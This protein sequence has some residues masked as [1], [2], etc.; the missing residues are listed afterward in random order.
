MSHAKITVVVVNDFA[1]INGGASKVAI[2]SA[3]S[4]S[5]AGCEVIF[6]AAVGPVCLQLVESKVRVI[7]LD[8]PSFV[9]DPK[10]LRAA[11]RGLWNF[12]SAHGFKSLL[13]TLDPVRTVVH[14]HSW[15]KALSSSVLVPARAGKFSVILTLHDYFTACPNGG[16]YNYPEQRICKLR[17]LSARCIG[18]NC[19]SRSYAYK[20]YRLLRQYVQRRIGGIPEQIDRLAYVSDFSLD[21][22]QD[23]L[24]KTGRSV[25]VD[26]PVE[27]LDTIEITPEVDEP[28]RFGFVGRMSP[29]KGPDLFIEAVTRIK[30]NGIMIGSGSEAL[31]YDPRFIEVTPWLPFQEVAQRMSDFRALVL[32]SRWYETQGL[33]VSEAA[34]LGVPAVVPDS[35][36]ASENVIHGETGLVFRSGDIDDLVAKLR[37]LQDDPIFARRLGQNARTA[38]FAKGNT[39]SAHVDRLLQVYTDL[40]ENRS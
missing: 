22:L 16:F 8:Q 13:K 35:S 36:A 38:F 20:V 34:C 29:E 3:V 12:Q 9:D 19:D 7:C 26:N 10:R 2:E 17:P 28:A 6:F 30:A 37:E 1:L 15:T 39:M 33:V 5:E 14:I 11:L 31:S 23:Y 4:L 27:V 32:T 21:I 25:R 40:L 24:G 18:T